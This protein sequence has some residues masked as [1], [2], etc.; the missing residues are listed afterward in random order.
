M[1]S[2]LDVWRLAGRRNKFTLTKGQTAVDLFQLAVRLDEHHLSGI[3]QEVPR[4]S[5]TGTWGG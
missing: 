5:R 4:L 1:V 2:G 3:R